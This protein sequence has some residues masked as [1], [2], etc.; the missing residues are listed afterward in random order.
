VIAKAV[1]EDRVVVSFPRP[2][3]GLARLFDQ[4]AIAGERALAL[5]R[6]PHRMPVLGPYRV[7]EYRPGAFLRLQRN[8]HYWKTEAGRR[9]PH[10]DSLHLAIQQN[11][12]LE[13]LRFLRGELDLIERMDPES[14]ERVGRRMP[15][16]A[17][18]AGPSLESEQMWFNQAAAAPIPDHRK[19]WFRSREFRRAISEAISR[20]DLCRVVYRGRALPAAGPV[21]PANRFWAH[22]RL[23]PHPHDPRAALK[24]LARLG[25]TPKNGLLHDAQGR[26]LE[27]SLITNAGNKARQRMAAMIQQDLARIGARVNVVALDFSSL[28]ERITRTLDYEACLLGLTNVDLDPNGQM[29]VWLSSADNHQWNPRQKS[30][31][32]AWEAE[33]DRLMRAQATEG[34]PAKRKAWFDR[35]QEIAW[36]EAP[37]LYLVHPHALAAV[38]PRLRQAAPAALRPQIYWN[39]ERLFFASGARR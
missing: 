33:I 19:A 18:D 21:S 24:R 16:A 3:A 27:F 29:N 22:A 30:P 28:L 8:P 36:E 34:S 4:V 6:E 11:R 2:V 17:V 9:L 5:A 20:D 25:F 35:V 14:F 23:A 10:L 37:F 39:V 32:T 12:D 7:A 26:P 31:E 15:A 38:S 1:G 13:V